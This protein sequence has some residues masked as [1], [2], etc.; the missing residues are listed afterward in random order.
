M[1]TQMS[2]NI[3]ESFRPGL[4]KSLL[5]IILCTI[6]FSCYR[7]KCDHVNPEVPPV[8]VTTPVNC[9]HVVTQWSNET[10]VNTNSLTKPSFINANTGWIGGANGVIL[11]TTDGGLT[12]TPQSS[13]SSQLIAAISFVDANIGYAA[14]GNSDPNGMILKT[15]D[16]GITWTTIL[17][18]I[19]T[20]RAMFFF[21]KD[22]G[23]VAG[24]SGIMR[25]TVD[26]GLS[27]T[28]VN[29]GISFG[30]YDIQF[31]DTNTGYTSGSNG[32]IIKTTNGGLSW[33]SLSNTMPQGLNDAYFAMDFLD[34]NNGYLAG[35]SSTNGSGY[36]IKTSNGGQSW[37]YMNMNSTRFAD[38]KMV[39]NN[40]V[41]VVGG[42]IAGGSGGIYKVTNGNTLSLDKASSD[43][44]F[45]FS[46]LG[47]N[48][49]IASGAAGIII[50]GN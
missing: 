7:K 32:G 21:N 41:Y 46:F 6:F 31:L 33:I 47:C 15:T 11:K 9:P 29:T 4:I 5:I 49:A 42:A 50:L 26:G 40:T 35:Y 44:L 22:T 25:K 1:K 8:V 23:F 19:Q 30:I 12:F 17:N 36:V 13:G 43:Q 48:K 34:V 38:I 18:N 39:D 3:S 10:S 37:S 45:G 28:T 14:G 2:K 20:V 27:W 24:S 16:G